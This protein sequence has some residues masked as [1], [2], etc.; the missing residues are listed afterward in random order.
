MK[1][2]K[3]YWFL[4][5]ITYMTYREYKIY[6]YMFIIFLKCNR[7]TNKNFGCNRNITLQHRILLKFIICQD[8]TL[9]ELFQQKIV[10]EY[11]YFDK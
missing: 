4:R 5:A 1:S 2:G 10:S 11:I 9:R 6:L 7:Q 8:I 3:Y